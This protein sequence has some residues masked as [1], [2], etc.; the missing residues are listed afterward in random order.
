[1]EFVV[2]KKPLEPTS[3]KIM[4]IKYIRDFKDHSVEHL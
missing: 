2:I 4:L 1:M 3:V